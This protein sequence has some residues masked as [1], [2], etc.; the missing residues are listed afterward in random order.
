MR[1]QKEWKVEISGLATVRAPTMDSTR[2][3]I[4][5]GGFVGEGH[6]EDG[7]RRH[8]DAVDEMRDAIGDDA[9][10]AAT[11]AGE[12]QHRAVDRLDGFTL[13]RVELG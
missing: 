5:D 10:L 3:A 13:L 12:D 8:A 11:G 4:S 1:T 6:R 2:L 7:V 9:R